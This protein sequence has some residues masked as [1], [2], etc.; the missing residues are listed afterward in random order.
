MGE[1]AGYALNEAIDA[2][3]DR[4]LYRQGVMSDAQAFDLGVIDHM[5]RYKHV[6]MYAG[7]RAAPAPKTCRHCG[8]T[9]LQWKKTETGWRLHAGEV[10]HVCF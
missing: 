8:A 3:N 9:G 10:L 2:E 1:F 5:G 6:P 4:W 7:V